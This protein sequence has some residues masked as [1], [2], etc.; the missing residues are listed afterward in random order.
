MIVEIHCKQKYE[1][2]EGLKT[3]KV[4]VRITAEI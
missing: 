1:Y 3:P 2:D 4:D